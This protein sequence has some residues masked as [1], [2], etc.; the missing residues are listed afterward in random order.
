MKKSELRNIIKETIKQYL[1]EQQS[2]QVCVE[3]CPCSQYNSNTNTCNIP[4]SFYNVDFVPIGVF[5]YAQNNLNTQWT[6][7]TPQVGDV[8]CYQGNQHSWTPGQCQTGN[9]TICQ[10]NP[11]IVINV[12]PAS[13]ACAGTSAGALRYLID[14]SA[15]GGNSQAIQNCNKPIS[16]EPAD[17]GHTHQPGFPSGDPT[18]CDHCCR[19]SGQQ[20]PYMPIPP[21]CKCQPGHL[22]VP[23]KLCQS[24]LME[25]KK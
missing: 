1:K 11:R 14:G 19:A 17:V 4:T 8:W 2:S 16:S 7:Q 18:K 21:A 6:S 5:H 10:Q 12:T 23:L 15:C 13:F 24:S 20:L 3:S 22:E 25:I 9:P